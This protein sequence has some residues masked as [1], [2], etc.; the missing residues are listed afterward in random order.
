MYDIFHRWC[1]L[2]RAKPHLLL[3]T[4]AASLCWAIWLTRN[5]VVFDKY[6]PKSFL[7]VVQGDA[8]APVVGAVTAP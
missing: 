7:Q 8:P 4:A 1:N 5:E 2:G 6:R 3:L